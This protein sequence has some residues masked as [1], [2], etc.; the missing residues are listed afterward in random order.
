LACHAEEGTGSLVGRREMM[1]EVSELKRTKVK[2][3]FPCALLST[4][5]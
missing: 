3:R 5:L 2:E 4:T 1:R